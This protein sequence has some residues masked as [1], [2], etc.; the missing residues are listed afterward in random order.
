MEYIV[1]EII[2]P[3]CK[4]AF[5]IDEA[6]FADIV[7]QVRNHEFNKEL[8]ERLALLEKEKE[9]ALFR[10]AADRDL[11]NSVNEKYNKNL[12]NKTKIFRFYASF[13]F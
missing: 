5:T 4:K 13:K 7:Q 6:G 2:C 9:N 10:E 8:H 11:R 12:K 1:N 3:H